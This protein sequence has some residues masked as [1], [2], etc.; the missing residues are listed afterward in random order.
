MSLDLSSLKPPEGSRRKPK[1]V[2]RGPGSG[3]GK[4]SGRGHKGQYSRSGAKRRPH[5][6]GGQMPLHRRLPKRGFWNPFRVDYQVVNVSGLAA[7]SAD[8][9]DVDAMIKMRLVRSRTK[10]VKVLGDGAIERAIVVSAH[11]FTK[12]AREKIE[13]AGGRCEVVE[14][15]N[16]VEV[17]GQ[18]RAGA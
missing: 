16:P 7:G 14:F 11:A 12:T 9:L 8:A 15:K 18:A 6:E 3:L 5:K 4:T 17:A 2:G 13:A 1:R 10:P